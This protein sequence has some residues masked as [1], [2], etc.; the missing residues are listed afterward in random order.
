MLLVCI[1]LCIALKAAAGN[2]AMGN[3]DGVL[4]WELGTL[5]AGATAERTA[6][7]ASAPDHDACARLIRSLRAG[8]TALDGGAAYSAPEPEGAAAWLAGQATD[9]ALGPGGAFFWEQAR[10]QALACEAGG[11]LS[12][13]GYYVNYPGG[14]TGTGIQQS[15]SFENLRII[16]PLDQTEEGAIRTVVESVDGRFRIEIEARLAREPAALLRFTLTNISGR[17]IE[18]ARLSIYANVES[19]H[20]HENDLATLD[21]ETGGVLFVDL[22]TGFCTVMTGLEPPDSGHA[23]TWASNNE[24][25]QG[26]GVARTDWPPFN[27]W[28][29]DMAKRFASSAIPHPPAP[30]VEPLEPETRTLTKDEA[31]AVLER[32][33]LFQAEGEPLVVRARK[34]TVWA[35]ELAARLEV[36]TAAELAALSEIEEALAL[37][38]ETAPDGKARDIYLAVRRVKRRITFKNPALD[39]DRVLFIDHPYTQ[40]AEWPHEAR[41]RNGMMAVPGGRLLVLDGLHPGGELVKLA[42][43]RPGSFWRPDLSFDADKVLFCYK[44]HDSKSFDLYEVGIDG[45]GL[46]QLTNSRYDDLDPIYLPDGHIMFSTTR[47]NTYIRCMPYTYAYVLARCDADGENVYLLSR[48]NEPDYLPTLLD[49]GRVIYTRWEYTDKALWRIQSLWTVNP[50]GTNVAVFW[51]N[52]S[53]WP[54]MLV[55][56]R[57][58][59]GSRRIMFTGAAHHN[60]F[61]GSIGI[62]D[63][64][65]GFN[66]PEGLTKVTADVAWPECGEP[67]VDP[68]ESARYHRSGA[69]DAY[70]TPYPIGA[71]D[72][73]VSARGNGKF[74]LYLMDVDGN[75]ELI[76]EGAHHI[77]HAMPVKPR[78]KPLVQPDRVAWPGTGEARRDPEPGVFYSMDIYQGVPELA[79]GS[80]KYLRVIQMDSRT[81]STWERDVP[82][83]QYSGPVIS[84][85]QADGV[86][87][88]L[89][90]VPVSENGAVAFEAPAGK[91]LHFQLL[92]EHYRAL[93]TMRSF[94]GVMPGER[95]GC[96]G[97]HELHSTAPPHR[98]GLGMPEPAA[99]T[100]PPWG[101]ESVSYE[102]FAQPILDEH[103]GEC[104]QGKGEARE[105]LDLTFRPGKGVFNEP[106]VTLVEKGIAGALLVENYPRSAPASYATLPPRTGLSYKSKLVEHAMSGKHHGVK[107]DATSLRRLIAWVDANCVYRGEEE[108][109][110]IPDP[111]FAGIDYLPVRPLCAS[112]PEIPR[113]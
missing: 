37:L 20:T 106:Y 16:R 5:T 8:E 74:R 22:P 43:E 42:P 90:T 36:N 41:H 35:R 78:K 97:C 102:R 108:V 96:V 23:G 54:D 75:R 14:R 86:K 105:K 84:I 19:R 11:Q 79:R 13:F 95:R 38:D 71:K 33:W 55:E 49:D 7:F 40:G 25:R 56:P 21:P 110:A 30:W 100:T 51:G 58:I 50:D 2:Q 34:E 80:V 12:R 60:W 45:T 63:P 44:P 88:I 81:Y 59:P 48:G 53:V 26:T 3:A 24:L 85:L 67:P 52:Q 17:T 82:P 10:R 104:H 73:L 89:G 98:Q 27:G 4:T 47:C 15:G 9:I 103:C 69:Y 18:S 72:F 31:S 64:A 76:Y 32:D 77:W 57:Q 91:A 94:T 111:D 28:S 61:D 107:M 1:C 68:V 6:V 99:L 66:F 112:A 29:D 92:D 93:Q 101:D 39:F 46:R 62:L 87:R 109:R 113:P 83:N 65:K 70:K